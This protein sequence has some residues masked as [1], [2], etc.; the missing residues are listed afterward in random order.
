MTIRVLLVGLAAA[1]IIAALM[2]SGLLERTELATL[3]TLFELRGPRPPAAPIVIVAI[4]EDSFDEMNMAWPFPRVLH[5]RLIEALN[6]GRPLA[7]GFD[8]LFPEPSL[9]GPADDAALGA[10]IARAGN[11]VL[12]AAITT[13]AESFYVKTDLNAPLPIIRKGA[14][15][16]GP[17]DHVKDRDAHI[18]RSPLR[19]ELG[20]ETLDAWDVQLYRLAKAAGLP[21]ADLPPAGEIVINYR[22]GP[23]TFPWVPYHRVLNGEFPPEQFRGKLVLVGPTSPI[24]QDLHSAPFAEARTMPGVEVHANVLD[25]L[26]RGDWIRPIPRWISVVVAVVLAFGSAWTVGQV[27]AL[28]ALVVVGLA[29]LMVAAWA[30]VAFTFWGLWF[31]AAGVSLAIVLGYGATVIDGFIREQREKRRLSQFFSPSVLREIVRH[32]AGAALGSRRRVVTVLFSDIRGFT[33]ISERLEPEVVAEM[34][35][36]YLTEMTEVVFRHRGTVDKYVGDCIM[37]LYNAPFDDPDHAANAIRTGLELQERTLAVSARWEAKLGVPIRNGVG[38][39]TGEAIVG[40][41][42]SRQRLEYTAIGDTVNLASRLESLT[43]DY[44]GGI[45]VSEDTHELVK[46]R[47][48][49]RQLGAVTVKGKARPVRI[50]GVLPADIR[51]YPR[52]ALDAAASV[53]AIGAG[54][55]CV[56]R[57]RNVGGGGISVVG[58]PAEWAIGTKIQIRLEGGALPG[59]L[60]VDGA[61]AWRDGEVAGIAFAGLEGDVPPAITDYVNARPQS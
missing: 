41:L 43:K 54:E 49:T 51:K 9:F 59:P 35:H 52:A 46:G 3:D 6:R 18:R 39:N 2:V 40:T 11:V 21:A 55:P 57:T 17:V 20:D 4:D 50:F 26:I 15:A 23:G 28:R 12:G 42:G 56:V 22:G 33:S 32:Q 1:A 30:F 38:V 47:F 61:V 53:V 48:L 60:V 8:V 19:H 58:L 37:A 13:V 44:G 16:V 29:W 27:R 10:A 5:G 25:T 14:A 45:I 24:L 31:Q 7:I 36:E 34:L